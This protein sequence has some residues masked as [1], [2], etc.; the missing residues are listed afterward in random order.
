MSKIKV[1]MIGAGGMANAVHY[2]SL[3]EMEDVE[4][5][6]ICDLQEDRLNHT[7]DKY[8]VKGRYTD[9]KKMLAEVD[10]D[11]VYVIMPPHHLFDLCVAVLNEG[12]PLCIEKPPCVTT[13]QIQQLA[14]LAAK[15]NA[16]TMVLFNRRY[17]PLMNRVRQKIE[18][19]GPIIQCTATFLKHHIGGGPYYNGAIDILRCDAIHAVDTLRWMGGEVKK[20]ASCVNSF[21]MDFGNSFNALLEFESGAVGFLNTNWAVGTRVHTFEMHAKGI[22]AFLNPDDDA[23]IY[24][25]GDAKGERITAVEAAGGREERYH[26]YGFFAENRHFIDCLKTKMQPNTCFADAVKTMELVD[27]IYQNTL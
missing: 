5:A 21:Y 13:F 3:H 9:Y 16:L 26:S 12:L 17:I 14:N 20:V 27:Q 6:A 25:D 8:D 2:P 24:A 19:R 1:G 23:V 15:K 18:E 10:L 11:C 22:S 4:I 7:A